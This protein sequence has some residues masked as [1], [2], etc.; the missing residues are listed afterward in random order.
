MSESPSA[1][2][3]SCGTVFMGT[4]CHDCG[5]KQVHEHDWTWSHFFH[6]LVHEIVHVDAK[7]FQTFW[8]LFRRPGFLTAE[9]WAG[10]RVPFLSPLRV[11][12]IG[13]AVHFVAVHYGLFR[14]N[15]IQV[16]RRESSSNEIMDAVAAIAG[17]ANR[18]EELHRHFEAV[19]KFTVY[20]GPLVLA[21]AAWMWFRRAR[22][23]FIQHLIFATHIYAFWFLVTP[24]NSVVG[25]AR[26]LLPFV[27]AVYLFFATRRLYGGSLWTNIGRAVFLRVALII[28]EMAAIGGA[29]AG[30]L[31]WA[32]SNRAH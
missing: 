6:H 12:L 24:L 20:L 18:A 26:V 4:Y 27:T 13:A 22:P 30:A 9:Y 14:T 25:R 10:R 11:Y 17:I 3:P 29:I 19:Y 31:F 28:A 15:V 21:A 32:F 7:I 8:L 1:S 23:Y 5:E 2:C 16:G